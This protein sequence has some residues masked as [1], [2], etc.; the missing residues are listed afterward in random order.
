MFGIGTLIGIWAIIGL[1]AD[2]SGSLEVIKGALWGWVALAFVLA[3]L[4]VAANA[5]VLVGAVAGQIPFGRCLALET[6][7]TFTS[8]VGGEVA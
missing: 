4:P 6:S 5:R 2:I 8:L 7:N 3:Q 1:L